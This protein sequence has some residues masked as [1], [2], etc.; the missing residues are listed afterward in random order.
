[1]LTTLI[2]R[3]TIFPEFVLGSS[4]CRLEE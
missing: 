3:E 1:M 4:N 2:P